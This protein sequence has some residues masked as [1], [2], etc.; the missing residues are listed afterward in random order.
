MDSISRTCNDLILAKK[1]S[2][3]LN[4]DFI[5]KNTL[6]FS[7]VTS[8]SV[9]AKEQ[10]EDLKNGTVLVAD[11][12]SHGRGRMSRGW[13]SPQG[14]GLWISLLIKEPLLE[15]EKL[16]VINLLISVV[17]RKTIFNICKK[18]LK[19]KWPNDLL[20]DGKKVCGILS[21]TLNIAG[22]TILISG[23]GIN[24]GK[25]IIFPP[26]LLSKA[27]SIELEGDS[28]RE[29]LLKKILEE[30]EQSYNILIKE[31][32]K[33]ML[34]EW[35]NYAMSLNKDIEI[36][37]SN[38]NKITARAIDIGSLGELIAETGE[39]ERKYIYSGDNIIWK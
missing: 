36:I 13:F 28:S 2:Q 24:T 9:F 14:Q 31:G 20:L 26:D 3:Y 23:F 37:G 6:F 15:I 21:E 30:F 12:Q 35:K 7:E 33:E 32:S 29:L 5:G 22:K 16:P 1:F 25:N 10:I 11:Y 39:G 18:M 4:T 8:T 34:K 17:I 38:N 19:I 27:T